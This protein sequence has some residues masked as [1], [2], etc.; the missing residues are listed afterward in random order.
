MPWS[1]RLLVTLC[2]LL[3]TLIHARPDERG[4]AASDDGDASPSRP[5]SPE[6]LYTSDNMDYT[7]SQNALN[8][9][10]CQDDKDSS[11]LDVH[12]YRDFVIS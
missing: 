2:L 10:H 11:T 6:V 1:S 4:L 5:P 3:H 9:L 8:L 7:A 12:S